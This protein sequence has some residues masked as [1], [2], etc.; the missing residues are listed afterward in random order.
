MREGKVILCTFSTED[1]YLRLLSG[2]LS[3][4]LDKKRYAHTLGV[5]YTAVSLA[6]AHGTDMYNAYLAG[7]LHDN[8]KCISSEKK[9]KLCKKYDIVLNEAEDK[10]PDLLHAKLGAIRAREKYH[11]EDR[12]VLEAIKYHTTG[13]PAMTELEKI[14]YIADYIE[15]NRKMLPGLP[16]IRATAFRDLNRAMVLILKNT[17]AYLRE[18]EVF[19]DP[20]TLKTYEYYKEEI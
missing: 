5:A 20:M 7:L 19:I 11:V 8:A 14:I 1:D 3:E 9:R 18:K 13:K 2:Q 4:E 16:E 15:P 12:A 6:M 17:L 10:N